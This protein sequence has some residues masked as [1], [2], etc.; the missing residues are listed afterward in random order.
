[1][2][3]TRRSFA[4][5]ARKTGAE[6]YRYTPVI[7]LTQHKDDSWTVHTKKG[8]I[9]AEIVVNAGGYRVNEIGAMMGFII[10]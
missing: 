4:R 9:D 3:S 5:S 7:G 1:M 8:D 6:I 10:R 2:T